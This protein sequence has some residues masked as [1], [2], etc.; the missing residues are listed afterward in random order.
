MCRSCAYV[1]GK[2]P[3]SF[4]V[5]STATRRLSTKNR[6]FTN[7]PQFV[8]TLHSFFTHRNEQVMHSFLR[9]VYL[10][11]AQI[12]PLS[13]RPTITTTTLFNNY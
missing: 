11:T 8:H 13:T 4:H 2:L 9:N 1:V 7:S 3:K 10:L 5:F 6:T 12:Y